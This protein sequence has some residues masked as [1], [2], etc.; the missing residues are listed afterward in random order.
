[1]QRCLV[2]NTNIAPSSTVHRLRALPG[3]LGSSCNLHAVIAV[4]PALEGATASACGMRGSCA[5][6][7]LDTTTIIASTTSSSK[8]QRALQQLRHIE[9][10]G[11]CLLFAHRL[12]YHCSVKSC[13]TYNQCTEGLATAPRNAR[14]PLPAAESMAACVALASTWSSSM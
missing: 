5:H 11:S 1:M 10:G 4:L 6:V 7:K 9:A 8:S 3:L 13:S 12:P 14:Q 2:R